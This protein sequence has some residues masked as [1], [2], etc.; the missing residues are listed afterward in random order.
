MGIHMRRRKAIFVSFLLFF[1]ITVP[2][3]STL[4]MVL[5][6]DPVSIDDSVQGAGQNEFNYTGPGWQHC[7]NC[8]AMLYQTTKSL[9]S[10][11][12]D[13]ASLLFFGTQLKFYGGMSPKGGLAE[14]SID[15][16]PATSISFYSPVEQGNKLL[17]TSS[18]LN[19]GPHTFNLHIIGTK[20]RASLGD[21][22]AVDR[23]E[24]LASGTTPVG[25]LQ[26]T[27]P[28]T[29]SQPSLDMT[30]APTFVPPGQ[31]GNQF[32]TNTP[33]G[34]QN[35]V[36]SPSTQTTATPCDTAQPQ[37][38]T[39][40]PLTDATPSCVSLTSGGLRGEYYASTD[41]NLLTLAGTRIDPVIA[42]DWS[43]RW[44]GM[45]P[46]TNGYSIRWTGYVQALYTETYYF[47]IEGDDGVRLAINNQWLVADPNYFVRAGDVPV[48]LV[49]GQLYPIRI[50]YYQATT[51]AGVLMTWSST[52]QPYEVVPASQLYPPQPPIPVAVGS[53]TGLTGEY[54]NATA[55]FANYSGTRTDPVISFDWSGG[56]NGMTPST[57]GYTVHWTGYVEPR[58]TAV[59]LFRIAVDDAA[60]LKVNNQWLIGNGDTN[61]WSDDST[62]QIEL[63]AGH[64]YPIV[65]DFYQTTAF[66]FISLSWLTIDMP[67]E[68]IPQTQLYPV[69]SSPLDSVSTVSP[70]A[71]PIPD[72]V[73][74]PCGGT[75]TPSPTPSPTPAQEACS[76]LEQNLRTAVQPFGPQQAS[77]TPP[78]TQPDFPETLHLQYYPDYQ[79]KNPAYYPD[80]TLWY[81][82]RPD[83][84][85]IPCALVD[86]NGTRITDA[87]G[88]VITRFAGPEDLQL[89]NYG[90]YFAHL[91]DDWCSP[92][93]NAPEA[94]TPVA[95]GDPGD[96][97]YDRAAQNRYL[98]QWYANRLL[99]KA[100]RAGYDVPPIFRNC[101]TE[102]GAISYG[103]YG[104][105]VTFVASVYRAMHYYYAAAYSD[106]NLTYDLPYSGYDL[107]TSG[108]IQPPYAKGLS[109]IYY[110]VGNPN[111]ANVGA[112][113]QDKGL[114]GSMLPVFARNGTPITYTPLTV[115]FLDN[116]KRTYG[117]TGSN[118]YV[119][120]NPTPAPDGTLKAPGDNELVDGHWGY[121][122]AQRELGVSPVIKKADQQSYPSINAALAVDQ[123]NMYGD[124]WKQI[125]PGDLVITVIE[126]TY[127]GSAPSDTN[128]PKQ[129]K[130][131]YPHIQMVVGWG[132]R[133]Y[134]KY[135]RKLYSS[136][137]AVV[138]SG[139]DPA[140]YVPY[141]MDRG[142]NGPNDFDISGKITTFGVAGNR[143]R[144]GPRPYDFLLLET[145][146][147]IWIAN[148]PTN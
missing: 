100:Y 56:F 132:L 115:Y 3:L 31:Q 77:A 102:T 140:D 93:Q 69:D 90:S 86:Q 45:T 128:D 146:V 120:L 129:F 138:Q 91:N 36:T 130:R 105:C 73:L 123:Q 67:P 107:N 112:L 54:Y 23:V 118:H 97:V 68:I 70:T 26:A 135:D 141:V 1:L 108:Y 30:L 71:S 16:N 101:I 136:Y 147:D 50:E 22:V 137:T 119:S 103:P 20:V 6:A 81:A 142:D 127:D 96:E 72:G 144:R 4:N 98:H 117:I 52:H 43:G 58:T 95:S 148:V 9:S 39:G 64:K 12:D 8:G 66:A 88:N 139:A 14:L 19:D 85:A 74:V 57:N 87:K 114:E 92:P 48:N 28:C 145:S 2:L 34:E 133:T 121:P 17:W 84:R 113:R 7:T 106:L 37:R 116:G 38:L 143:Q 104:P 44:N 32:P 110:G 25:Q 78:Y 24:I 65:V 53:G 124:M 99:P 125:K 15:D 63:Q 49:A 122:L 80:K 46:S 55:T 18:I 5:A 42:F 76:T 47:H 60:R 131:E 10:S 134:Q 82:D 89:L 62:G 75:P 29:T 35:T 94:G 79:Q 111:A 27:T 109:N 83:E 21:E 126:T 61:T 59:Y 41:F 33:L 13:R 40:A 51:F 11:T